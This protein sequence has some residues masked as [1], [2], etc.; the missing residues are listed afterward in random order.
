MKASLFYR[1]AAVV[2]VLFAIAHT[3]GFRQVDPSWG[4][5]PLL[6]SM[7]SIHFNLQGSSRTYWE[8]YIALG[9]SLGT[10]LLFSAVL[11]WQLGGLQPE[12][13]AGVR[14]TVWAFPLC[15]AV[16]TILSWRFLFVIPVAF[17]AVTT[18]C[19]T[20]AAGLSSKRT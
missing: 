14:L 7:R 13:L 3:L 1:I 9:F 10:L 8:L 6:A 12:T 17:S 18:A 4:I 11:A 15:F 20:V 16:I 19:L 2:L 5:G